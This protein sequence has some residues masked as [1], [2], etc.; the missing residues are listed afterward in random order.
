MLILITGVKP[1]LTLMRGRNVD[2]G[3]GVLDR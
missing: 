3:F 1:E 2:R